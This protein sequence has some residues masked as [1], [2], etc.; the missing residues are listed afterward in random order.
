MVGRAEKAYAAEPPHWKEA[1]WLIED[2]LVRTLVFTLL[3]SSSEQGCFVM[4]EMN[5]ARGVLSSC[6]VISCLLLF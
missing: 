2:H 6:T 3:L 1:M 4:L 5:A